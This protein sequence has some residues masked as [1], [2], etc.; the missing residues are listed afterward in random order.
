MNSTTR[1]SLLEDVG[2]RVNA[3]FPKLFPAASPFPNTDPSLVCVHRQHLA[4]RWVETP[5]E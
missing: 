1:R 4:L 2:G 5:P 3:F